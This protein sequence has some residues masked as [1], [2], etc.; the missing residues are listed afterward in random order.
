MG[1]NRVLEPG[2]FEELPCFGICGIWRWKADVGLKGA[3]ISR[4]CSNGVGDGEEYAI[5]QH[6]EGS[7]LLETNDKRLRCVFQR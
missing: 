7:E 1:N 2:H 6:M 4:M 3:F 5:L